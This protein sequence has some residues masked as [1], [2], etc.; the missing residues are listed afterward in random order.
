MRSPSNAA[1]QGAPKATSTCATLAPSDARTT[2]SPSS[3]L[4]TRM[5]V[6][7]KVIG[8]DAPERWPTLTV[9]RTTP[10]A[11]RRAIVQLP[12]SEIQTSCPSNTIP[13]GT[14]K[15]SENVFTGQGAVVAGEM[16]ET[17]PAL[18]AVQSRAPSNAG[19]KG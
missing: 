11:S 18:F 17:E 3:G 9:W 16:V 10:E 12:A 2:R 13:D 4:A 5:W 8:N 14:C 1:A 19:T 7:S 15:P 6:P